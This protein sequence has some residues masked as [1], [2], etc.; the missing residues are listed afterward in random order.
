MSTRAVMITLPGATFSR[1][2]W[3]W[4]GRWFR[5]LH[6]ADCLRVLALAHDPDHRLGPGLADQEPPAIAQR[7][8]ARGHGF[9]H[10]R[11]LE[12][13]LG[14]DTAAERHV[15]EHLG[16]RFENPGHLARLAAVLNQHGEHLERRDQ[17]VA[18]GGIVAEHDM[19]GLL[20]T[21]VVTALA[22]ALDHVTVADRGAPQIQAEPAQVA[23]QAQV[24]HHRA[25][26]AAALQYLRLLPGMGDQAEDLVAIDQ[27]AALVGHDHTVGVAVER[28]A[29]I[30][31]M[32]EHRLAQR[33]R[34]GGTAI[35][36][37]VE[38]VGLDRHRHHLGAKLVKHRRRDLVGGAVG[39]IDH[40]LQTVEA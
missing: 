9:A 13:V 38:T 22:H 5:P 29:E 2:P 4:C 12:C 39:A 15:L 27:A 19:A 8:F 21:Q 28:D 23:L 25:D 26:D 3:R 7:A 32:V 31:A 35:L 14:G 36:V 40:D 18:G 34:R 6:F 20:A 33:G 37:D 24:G 16:Q 17:A 30:G 10:R 1:P 11:V